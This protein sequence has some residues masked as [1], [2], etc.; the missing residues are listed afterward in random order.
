MVEMALADSRMMCSRLLAQPPD[1]IK[2]YRELKQG[3][4]KLV[5]YLVH[6]LFGDV[7]TPA[8]DSG[9]RLDICC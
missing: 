8:D 2:L 3:I 9:M 5:Y 1:T 6:S 4:T 7:W